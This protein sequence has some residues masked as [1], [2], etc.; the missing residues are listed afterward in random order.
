M[1]PGGPTN[2]SIRQQAEFYD[3]F[4]HAHRFANRLQ[5][6]R[7]VAIL[8]A[9][10]ATGLQEPDIIELG[11]GTGWFTSILGQFGPAL[12]V[13][14]SSAAVEAATK[15]FPHAR[16]LAADLTT[17]DAPSAKFDVVVST[18]VIEHVEDP[19]RHLALAHHLLRPGGYLILTTPNARTMQAMPEP[20]RAAWSKQPIENWLT[21]AQLER[22]LDAGGFALRRRG[23]VVAGFG[24]RGAYRIANSP[25]LRAVFERMGLRGV[26]DSLRLAA[27]FGL[28]TVIL[29]RRT[30]AGP[31]P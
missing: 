31:G 10:R 4:W 27:G 22:L 9:L 5:L 21:I 12:G 16:Y 6:E 26:F 8:A 20:M 11:C 18:E 24:E 1:M 15:R 7:S 28:H 14:L 23:T 25:R 29:A 19:A 2:P 3:D 17:W 30:G 13:E